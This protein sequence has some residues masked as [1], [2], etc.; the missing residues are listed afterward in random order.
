MTR[1]PALLS[2]LA[3]R[4][5][6]FAET[7]ARG[8]SP[9]YEMLALAV[10]RSVEILEFIAGLPDERQ[11][12]NLFLAAVRTSAGIPRNGDD[13]AAAVRRHAVE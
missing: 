5:V 9:T 3:D 10:S 7:E 6:R 1:P 4:Y 12:P 11:Q 2:K 8:S 13:L